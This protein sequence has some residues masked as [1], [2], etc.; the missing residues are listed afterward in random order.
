[1]MIYDFTK[2]HVCNIALENLSR[3]IYIITQRI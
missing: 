3:T 2:S 1:M